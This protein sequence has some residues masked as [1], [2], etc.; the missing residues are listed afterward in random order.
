[1]TKLLFQG[2]TQGPKPKAGLN[3]SYAGKA[4][5]GIQ[6]MNIATERFGDYLWRDPGQVCNNALDSSEK[7]SS[8]L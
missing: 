5:K 2:K 7:P 8:S 3:T 6:T 1:V 4:T